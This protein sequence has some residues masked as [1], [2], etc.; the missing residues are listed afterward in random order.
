MYRMGRRKFK[1]SVQ[2]KNEECKKRQFL[3]SIPYRVDST[4]NVSIP[5]SRLPLIAYKT[6]PAP[7]L[8]CLGG[9]LYKCCHRV[10]TCI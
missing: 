3:T 10:C 2:R 6:L 7:S 8:V 9:H 4:M 1:L 5:L